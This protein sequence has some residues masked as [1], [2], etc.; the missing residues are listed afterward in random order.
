MRYYAIPM[1]IFSTFVFASFNIQLYYLFLFCY[2]QSEHLGA[3]S[4]GL[5]PRVILVHFHTFVV[6]IVLNVKI[7][8]PKC[9]FNQKN[10]NHIWGNKH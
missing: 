10:K 8:I 1:L 5:S 9:F 4:A 7:I 2:S 3:R 6:E